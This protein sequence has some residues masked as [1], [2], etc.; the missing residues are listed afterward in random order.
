M[1][2]PFKFAHAVDP[3][4]TRAA[5]AC[6]KQLGA[7]PSAATLGFLY[8]SDAFTGELDAILA[9]FKSATAVPHWTGSVGVGVCASGV[10][11]LG[12]PAMAVMLGEFEP[13]DFSMLPLLRTPQDIAAQ[14][15]PDAYFAMVHGDPASTRIQE[16]IEGLSERVSSGFVV[17]GLSSSEGVT[18]QVCDG[19]V[20]GGLSGVLFSERVKLATRLTQGVSP[21]GPRHRVTA[22]NKNVIGSLDHRPALDVM[23]EEIGEV[24]AHDLRRAAGYIFVGLPVRGSD[25]GDY[26]V[27]NI[28]GVDPQN[29]LVAVGET[30]EPGDELLFCRRDRQSAEADLQRMLAAIGAQLNAP[31]RG[32]VYYSC[33]GRGQHMFGAPNREMELIRDALGDFPLVG[34]FANGEISHNRL[35]GYTGVLTLFG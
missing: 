13:T 10:E 18:A 1:T 26:L 30:V 20:S 3:D 9:F 22:A 11:Y 15:L 16:L 33:L 34:F 27:R 2:T 5:Q 12:Q 35:Y 23:K 8:V 28:L 31:I 32:G 24:L 21:L 25:T 14:P 6:M 17:G 19:V 4:W 7:I 29:H